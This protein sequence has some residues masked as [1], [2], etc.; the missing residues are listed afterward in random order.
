MNTKKAG[1]TIKTKS[2][3]VGSLLPRI[4]EIEMIA[5]S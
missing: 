1:N 3:S 4:K 2:K 5:K